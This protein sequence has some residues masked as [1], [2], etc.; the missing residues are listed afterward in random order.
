VLTGKK[1]DRIFIVSIAVEHE[2]G[3][4]VRH[5]RA[6][7]PPRPEEK[8]VTPD[9]IPDDMDTVICVCEDVTRRQ[10]E[11]VIDRDR[12]ESVDEIKRLL[13]CG[14]GP[15]Q[16]KTCQRLIMQILARKLGR[17]VSAF[18]PQTYRGPMKPAP[19]G[20]LAKAHDEEEN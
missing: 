7:A 1:F 6:S 2:Y 3:D 9:D 19:M 15:C 5:F 18:L 14:M 11:E 4:T 12:A 20:I 13:R 8:I 10:V 17:N 16:G